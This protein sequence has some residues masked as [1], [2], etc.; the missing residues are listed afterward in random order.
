VTTNFAPGFH[1]RP[2]YEFSLEEGQ[3]FH[4]RLRELEAEY[5][6]AFETLDA[7]YKKKREDLLAGG[8]GHF[9]QG[10][11]HTQM[12]TIVDQAGLLHIIPRERIVSISMLR[13]EPPGVGRGGT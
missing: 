12:L 3:K 5:N 4:Q 2:C 8:L 10:H 13:P 6:A 11:T 1:F 9:T 7:I